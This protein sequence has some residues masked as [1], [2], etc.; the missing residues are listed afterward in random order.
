[1]LGL[2]VVIAATGPT[3]SAHK[4][5]VFAAGDGKRIT[6]YAYFPGGG[7]ARGV[8]V[9]ALAPDGTKLGEATTNAEGEFAIPV[10][11]RCDYEVVAQTADGHRA[12]CPVKAA[13][14]ADDLPPFAAAVAKP[15][16]EREPAAR[17]PATATP[18]PTDAELQAL[19]ERAVRE[20]VR[21]LREQ[22]E[23][24]EERTRLRDI[25]GGIGYIMGLAGL[26]FY[27]LGAR[28]RRARDAERPAS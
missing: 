20:E 2:L 7:R 12:S 17:A 15:T 1:M 16:T 10:T 25:L 6:G 9:E 23:G 13:D 11:V 24:Y 26:A 22:L 27:F 28:R 19:V 4:L 18:A 5:K 21:P 3:A 8:P 14:L